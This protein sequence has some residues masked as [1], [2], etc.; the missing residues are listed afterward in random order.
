V[1]E[2]IYLFKNGVDPYSGGVFYQVR[3]TKLVLS[4]LC[5]STIIFFPSLLNPG[6]AVVSSLFVDILDSPPAEPSVE[7]GS[8]DAGRR[9]W[10]VRSRGELGERGAV[11]AKARETYYSLLCTFSTWSPRETGVE[12]LDEV[13]IRQLLVQPVSVSPLAGVLY[14]VDIEHVA[15][16]EYHVRCTRSVNS[17]RRSLI[18]SSYHPTRKDFACALLS[19][20]ARACLLVIHLIGVAGDNALAWPAR[21]LVWPTQ[22]DLHR[23]PKR[24]SIGLEFLVYF[25]VLSVTSTLVSGGFQ[26]MWQTW[27]VECVQHPSLGLPVDSRPFS[28]DSRSLISPQ[29]LGCGG[30][31]SPRCLITSVRS[32]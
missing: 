4:Q 5:L 19:R 11:P 20:G 16:V 30:I 18:D 3:S 25:L 7:P 2:G 32:S 10:C 9:G 27:F 13:I 15:L 6:V 1:H 23:L 14:V 8:L 17:Q 29:T 21:S 26:W 12:G 31:S 24:E 28:T 22:T